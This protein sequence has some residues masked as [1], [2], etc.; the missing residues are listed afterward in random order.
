MDA[1]F[2]T[3]IT[4]SVM[5]CFHEGHLN[6]L[7]EMRKIADKTIVIIHD[8]YSTFLNKKRFTVQPLKQRIKN[9]KKT[10]L[11]D[12]IIVTKSQSPYKEIKKALCKNCIYVRGDDWQD[13]PGRE[14]LDDNKIPIRFIKYTEGV[15]T[16]Q[17]REQLK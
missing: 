15:S 11:V 1:T 8:D 13:F 17:I 6:L 14:V 9:L 5:D 3:A 4:A 2:N 7:T 12:K 16:S 10:G